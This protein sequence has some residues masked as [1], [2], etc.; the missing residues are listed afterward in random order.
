MKAVFHFTKTPSG[1]FRCEIKLMLNYFLWSTNTT[2][3]NQER[4]NRQTI[5]FCFF[6]CMWQ[7][8]NE[9][10]GFFRKTT[11]F[12]DSEINAESRRINRVENGHFKVNQKLN[13]QMEQWIWHQ[14]RRKNKLLTK[15]RNLFNRK[16]LGYVIKSFVLLF[17][18]FQNLQ[19]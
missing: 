3:V 4:I 17:I 14:K 11:P 8:K 15:R 1:W 7:K 12:P 16:I 18:L 6:A 10:S 5:I 13:S 9:L 19:T 2:W